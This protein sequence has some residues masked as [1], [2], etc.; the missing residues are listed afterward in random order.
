MKCI[1]VFVVIEDGEAK[2][3]YEETKVTFYEISDDA[4]RALHRDGRAYG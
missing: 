2:T 4:D 1:Q 3:F